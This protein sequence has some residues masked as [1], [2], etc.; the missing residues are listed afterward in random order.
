MKAAK[1][2]AIT[3][4]LVLLAGLGYGAY[5]FFGSGFKAN[6]PSVLLKQTEPPTATG[7]APE[8]DNV[9]GAENSG[10]MI[11]SYRQPEEPTSTEDLPSAKATSS[12]EILLPSVATSTES[13]TS[14]SVASSTE[15]VSGEISLPVVTSTETSTS[16]EAN[17]TEMV[18]TTN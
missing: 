15:D 5:R 16:T 7:S 18:T 6:Q 17:Q 9:A 12:P 1:V 13:P 11:S 2:A 10:E 8:P 4:P 3:V 14:T